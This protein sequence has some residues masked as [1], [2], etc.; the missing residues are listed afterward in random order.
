[1]ARRRVPA[2]RLD[3]SR[4]PV[5]RRPDGSGPLL[6][7]ATRLP[8]SFVCTSRGRSIDIKRRTRPSGDV[9][10]ARLDVHGVKRLA[11]SHEQPVSLR[12]AEAD[13]GADLR[14]TYLA[15][16]VAVRRE[17]VHA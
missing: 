12:A 2:P 8:W 16:S 15:N 14:Q 5:E 1:M 13:I 3:Q 17:D 6:A 7:R 10:A 11:G 9:G 4:S